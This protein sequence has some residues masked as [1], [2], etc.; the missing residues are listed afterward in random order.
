MPDKKSIRQKILGLISVEL[1]LEKICTD[2]DYRKEIE[3]LAR[4]GIGGF[5]VKPGEAANAKTLLEQLQAHAET[6]LTIS[7]EITLGL[8]DLIH[9][10]TEF[11][12]LSAII[13]NNNPGIAF[14]TGKAQAREAKDIGIMKIIHR[15]ISPN[16]LSGNTSDF[17]KYALEI[18]RG[19]HSEK[20][21]SSLPGFKKA[22]ETDLPESK[23]RSYFIESTSGDIGGFFLDIP[24]TVPEDIFDIILSG[25]APTARCQDDIELNKLVER[26]EADAEFRK[27]VES[28]SKRMIYEKRLCGLLPRFAR[29]EKSEKASVSN[30]NFALKTAVTACD[31][32]DKKNILP[33]EEETPTAIFAF[34]ENNSDMRSATRFYTMTAQASDNQC[35]FGF[36]NTAIKDEE[37]FD[38]SNS[39]PEEVFTVFLFFFRDDTVSKEY[40]KIGKIINELTR[41]RNFLVN[42]GHPDNSNFICPDNSIDTFSDSFPSLAAAVTILFGRQE[43]LK[44]M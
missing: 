18:E 24:E 11:P 26:A 23:F 43:A 21:L 14:N 37:L 7:G 33:L 8:P 34:I 20:L 1:D 40:G 29:Q 9:D 16:T 36:I 39:L 31:I 10:G 2:S 25:G 19:I 17:R 6:P 27:A 22:D 42:F 3:E 44:T 12:H 32:K 13:R 35:D 38:L 41:D 4:K 30:M 28:L 5:I 15:E